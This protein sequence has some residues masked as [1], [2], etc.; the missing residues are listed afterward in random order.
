MGESYSENQGMV[1]AEWED[2]MLGWRRA[3]DGWVNELIW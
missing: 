3:M 1:D 2:R